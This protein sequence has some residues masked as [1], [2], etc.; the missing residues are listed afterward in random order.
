MSGWMYVC[1]LRAGYNILF[2]LLPE[3]VT[4]PRQV[5]SGIFGT[6]KF[7]DRMQ[8]V[9]SRSSFLAGRNE[10]VALIGLKFPLS[11]ENVIKIET[12]AVQ[13][14]PRTKDPKVIHFEMTTFVRIQKKSPN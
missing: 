1:Q 6:G 3:Q 8:T 9:I 11:D 10:A 14:C 5:I 7:R 12:V 13:C 2:P 4:I